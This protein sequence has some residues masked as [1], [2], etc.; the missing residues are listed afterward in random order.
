MLKLNNAWGFKTESSTEG[1]ILLNVGVL[2]L[3]QIYMYFLAGGFKDSSII[4][5]VKSHIYE[6]NYTGK[7]GEKTMYEFFS[8]ISIFIIVVY[9]IS[10]EVLIKNCKSTKEFDNMKNTIKNITWNMIGTTITTVTIIGVL[11]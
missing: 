4:S 9:L 2:T 3:W 11:N 1:N 5:K 10:N 7:S 6:D 8:F